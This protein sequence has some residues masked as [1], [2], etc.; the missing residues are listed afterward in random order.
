MP[1]SKYTGSE[2]YTVVGYDDVNLQC[3][4]CKTDHGQKFTILIRNNT[5]NQVARYGVNCAI[6]LLNMRDPVAL[7][8]QAKHRQRER[9]RQLA[10][11]GRINL[12]NVGVKDP[13]D[14]VSE[15][16]IAPVYCIYGEDY[17]VEQ[18]L[19]ILRDRLTSIQYK[20]WNYELFQ[21]TEVSATQ[22][23]SSARMSPMRGTGFKVIVIRHV[24]DMRDNDKAT[25]ARYIQNPVKST[26]LIL[27]ASSISET[28]E[29]YK[30]LMKAM[31]SNNAVVVNFTT[32]TQQQVPAFLRRTA[33][34]MGMRFEPGAA[35]Q[36]SE[37]ISCDP[38][39]GLF[40]LRD[41]LDRLDL[42]M[43]DERRTVTS[44]DVEEVVESSLT[45]TVGD[46]SLALANKDKAEALKVLMIIWGN[47]TERKLFDELGLL[48]GR[49]MYLVNNP[50]PQALKGRYAIKSRLLRDKY[51]A[52]STKWTSED[53]RRLIDSLYKAEQDI[54]TLIRNE[55]R[56]SLSASQSSREKEMA[57]TRMILSVLT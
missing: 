2:Q 20:D 57:I 1:I 30:S 50:D 11:S 38:Q 33:L 55:S 35:E 10:S 26:I 3:S 39:T 9:L 21:G 13:L 7:I 18:A 24:D 31:D 43:G 47:I 36:L 23:V 53:V 37:A 56:R 22:V 34:M 46:L 41:A 8:T 32:P 12:G 17:Y 15:A 16:E 4:D 6:K 25:L 52:A 27:T 29:L 54:Q 19:N 5:T 40:M 49:L 51:V 44:K 45:K 28:S 14:T 42:Y 48:A